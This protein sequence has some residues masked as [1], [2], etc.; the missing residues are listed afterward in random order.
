[1]LSGG[2]ASST[3]SSG[4]GIA[5]GLASDPSDLQSLATV[6]GGNLAV[7]KTDRASGGPV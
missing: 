3:T 4:L 6:L 5:D 1:V 7:K 2:V